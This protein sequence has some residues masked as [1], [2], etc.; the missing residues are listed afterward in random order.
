[1]GG[2]RGVEI[3][4]RQ[5]SS[6]SQELSLTPEQQNAS[7]EFPEDRAADLRLREEELEE[8]RGERPGGAGADPGADSGAPHG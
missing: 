8:R 6:A 5:C 1:M 4:P 7:S 3:D 2:G